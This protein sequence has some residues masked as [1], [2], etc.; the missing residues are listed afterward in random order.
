MTQWRKMC[1]EAYE[2]IERLELLL[3]KYGLKDE[4]NSN[5]NIE[6]FE[7]IIGKIDESER[8]ITN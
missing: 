4:V 2:E 5:R 8:D 6:A 7:A 1:M 3:L